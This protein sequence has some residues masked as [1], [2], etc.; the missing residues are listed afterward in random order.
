MITIVTCVV[1][2]TNTAN[3]HNNSTCVSCIDK[4]FKVLK[5]RN[6]VGN[7]LLDVLA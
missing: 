1:C 2:K 4:S 3:V 5:A 6:S 7:K